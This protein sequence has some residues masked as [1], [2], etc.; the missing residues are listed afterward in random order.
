M[1]V[2]LCKVDLALKAFLKHYSRNK[3]VIVPLIFITQTNTQDRIINFI[4]TIRLRKIIALDLWVGNIHQII[5]ILVT[6][7]APHCAFGIWVFRS[8]FPDCQF[9][10]V[11]RYQVE[12]RS[13]SIVQSDSVVAA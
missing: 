13:I 10:S 5:D 11:N 3:F 2:Q 7:T 6:K 8:F 12:G 4:S 9:H 1:N